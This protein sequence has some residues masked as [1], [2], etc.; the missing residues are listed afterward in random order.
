MSF[1]MGVYSRGKRITDVPIVR[2]S[3]QIIPDL[4]LLLPSKTPIRTQ[5]ENIE[6]DSQRQHVRR[7]TQLRRDCQGRKLGALGLR[8]A[9]SA[10]CKSGPE[11]LRRRK[12]GEK[13]VQ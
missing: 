1:S 5:C 3:V 9:E 2:P 13:L 6:S 11:V 12:R 7:R 4:P 8:P 10:V